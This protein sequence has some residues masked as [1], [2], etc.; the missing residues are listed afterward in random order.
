[1]KILRRVAK[2]KRIWRFA[3]ERAWYRAFYEEIWHSP[4]VNRASVAI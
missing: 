1:M 4:S 2:V 3:G